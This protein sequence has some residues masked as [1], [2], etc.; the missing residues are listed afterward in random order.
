MYGQGQ[1]SRPPAGVPPPRMSAPPPPNNFQQGLLPTPH[2]A[3]PR[4]AQP[5]HQQTPLLPHP[6]PPPPRQLPPGGGY[7]YL[8]PPQ[9]VPGSSQLPHMYPA[10]QQNLARGLPPPP[11]R[12]LVHASLQGQM[13]YRAPMHHLAQPVPPPPPPPP[14]PGSS[15]S[16]DL[17]VPPLPPPKPAEEKTV[18]KIEE[19][20]RLIAQNGASY[21]D[22]TRQRELKNPEFQFLFG[23]EP[24]SEAAV[25]YEYF[26]WMKKQRGL[27]PTSLGTESSV[28]E[29]GHS[30]S[31]AGRHSPADSDMEM[32]DDI[33]QS[34]HDQAV[35]YAIENSNIDSNVVGSQF[36]VKEHLP[37]PE[38]LVAP[39][40]NPVEEVSSLRSAEC[41]KQ[42]NDQFTCTRSG[43]EVHIPA[44]SSAEASARP[45]ICNEKGFV[46]QG[47]EKNSSGI[48]YPDQGTKGSSP[49]RL[50]QNYA[51]GDSSEN[52]EEPQR[53]SAI[54]KTAPPLLIAGTDSMHKDK[55]ISYN[56]KAG[57][58]SPVGGLAMECIVKHDNQASREH[59]DSAEVFPKAGTS[60]GAV[61]K[62]AL[63]GKDQKDEDKN[64]KR[65]PPNPQKI[66]R[67]GRLVREGA[68][69]SD[70]DDS[71]NSRRR[72]RRGKSRSRSRSPVD[73]RRR[74]PRRSPRRRRRRSRSRSWSPRHRRSRSRSPS[75]KHS[76]ESVSSTTRRDKCFNF[77]RGRCHR[78]ASCR[79]LHHD[80]DKADG[81]RHNRS[82]WQNLERLPSSKNS[83]TRQE[84]EKSSYRLSDRDGGIISQEMQLNC[85]ASASRRVAA[86]DGDVDTIRSHGKASQAIPSSLKD[87]GEQ[88][89]QTNLSDPAPEDAPHHLPQQTD[90]SPIS[91]LLPGKTSALSPNE[92]S[93]SNAVA[94][95]ADSVNNHPLLPTLPSSASLSQT[96]KASQARE[97]SK[98]LNLFAQAAPFLSQSAPNVLP[99]HNSLISAPPNTSWSSLRQM[100]P[101]LPSYDS[102]KITG[103]ATSSASLQFQQSQLPPRND[104]GSQTFAGPYSTEL[105]A[106]SRVGE[107]QH[108]AYPPVQ[109][110]PRTVLHAQDVPKNLPGHNLSNKQFG[111]PGLS[112]ED[113]LAGHP[114]QG[115]SATDS[116][117]RGKSYSRSSHLS[118]E[119]PATKIQYFPGDSLPSGE[120]INS[121]SQIQPHLHQQQ[122]PYALHQSGPDSIHGAHGNVSSSRPDTLDRNLL[123]HPSEFVLPRPSHYNPYASNF[124]QPLNSRFSSDVFRQEK[125]SPYASKYSSSLN[126]APVDGQGVN[127]GSRHATA[128]PNSTW[129]AGQGIR[130]P[131]GNQY[132]PIF[133]S[134]EPSTNSLNKFDH[135]RN[136]ETSNDSSTMS[137]FIPPSKP[138]DVEE[139]NRK[140]EYGGFAI[141]PSVEHEEFGETADA[142]VGDIENGSQSNA[143]ALSDMDMGEME[144]D[145]INSPGK[146][147]KSK[148]HRSM[149]LFRVA[150]AAFV[151]DVLKPSWRQ[152]NM[153]KEAF[154]TVVKKTVDKV[155]GAMKSHQIPKSKTKIDHY[156]DSSRWKLTK[157]VMIRMLRSLTFDSCSTL[158]LVVTGNHVQT[159]VSSLCNLCGIKLDWVAECSALRACLQLHRSSVELHIGIKLDW[160]AECSAVRASLQ[161]HGSSVEL[162]IGIELYWDAECSAVGA[163]LQLHGSSVEHHILYVVFVFM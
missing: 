118:Q 68:S 122:F 60:G 97:P 143:N 137:R 94:N 147:K 52:G 130:V 144:I 26:M 49:F 83:N 134:I 50:L 25:A 53:E 135:S 124:E 16:V 140:E 11:P 79:Y 2:P 151:K 55:D 58:P 54:S 8:Q 112:R 127:V 47:D 114:V 128:A 146:S 17:D 157:L 108:Q 148:E 69:D 28:Q 155:S 82:K 150:L 67:F 162:H 33:S 125:D 36:D 133:D 45:S 65:A 39:D 119:T 116:F 89:P 163:S 153:S 80:L 78:G 160:D 3:P 96:V 35:K 161:L 5:G 34:D 30:T 126:H 37:A 120:A 9:P 132:D 38:S 40:A 139:N 111:G 64:T 129:G 109:E 115:V 51:S 4:P 75:F 61:S 158:P 72:R 74:S 14:P 156:I 59:A 131:G 32:E 106:P 76:G 145:Q 22:I 103:T 13:L 71:L 66:D 48:L 91:D 113:Y 85:D 159:L 6:P 12:G 62:V 110:A 73:R 123:S 42:G 154:K 7:S 44:I 117:A 18:Q 142:E 46:P 56:L 101:P 136:L 20:C 19:L 92:F 21:E 84:V 149:K 98:D 95:T 57:R 24:G 77:L 152:G 43:S 31:F 93:A 90:D 88:Q 102:T 10:A 81:S 1:A 121:S 27:P 63:S 29:A 87:S 23:G 41:G 100:L 141:A 107:I 99:N 15:L 86:R 70:S 138:L 104:F 105:L